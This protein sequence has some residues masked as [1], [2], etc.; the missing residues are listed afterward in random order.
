MLTGEVLD[1]IKAQVKAEVAAEIASGLA[2]QM[3]GEIRAS[4]MREVVGD[5][6]ATLSRKYLGTEPAQAL[7]QAGPTTPASPAGQ[8]GLAGL[9]MPAS[10]PRAAGAADA[11]AAG[12]P[13]GATGAATAAPTGPTPDTSRA[14][15]AVAGPS[16]AE[17]IEAVRTVPVRRDKADLPVH[18]VRL[19]ATREQGGTR[20]RTLTVGGASAMPFHLWEGA[21]P[22]R[23]L[24]AMEVFDAVSDKYPAVLRAIHGDLLRH[25]AEMAKVCVDTYGADLISVRLDGTHPERGNKSAESAVDLVKSVLAAV[26]VPLIVTGH[27]HFERVSEVMKSVAQACAGENLLLNWVENDN[28]RTIAGAAA[29]YGHCLVAQSPIDVNIAKQLNILLGNMDIGPGRILIDPMTGA[30]GYGLEYTYS[31][32]ERI[33]LTGLAGDPMLAAPLI[34]NPGFE[35]A[36]VKEL[37]AAEADFPAWGDLTRRAAMWELTT[38]TG[39]LHAGADILVMYHP[40]AAMALKRTIQRLMDGTAGG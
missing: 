13:T 21:M 2:E 35:C 31:V 34:V 16:A 8:A 36:R 1:Q 38:A 6:V 37:K 20:G 4:L 18:A 12:S 22:N 39:F 15:A 23:P 14:G 24:V 26:D 3:R 30:L 11:P 32:M 9:A 33:R 17:R 27:S 5:I 19:G 28:Y 10:G 7:G 25:P 40:E 29:A